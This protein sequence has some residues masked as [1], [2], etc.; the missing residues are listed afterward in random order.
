[1]GSIQVDGEVQ[2][3]T[4]QVSYSHP[5]THSGILRFSI[6]AIGLLVCFWGIWTTGRAGLSRLLATNVKRQSAPLTSGEE[7][8]LLSPSDPIPYAARAY[9]LLLSERFAEAATDYEAAIVR[10]PNDH[11]LWL[12]LGFA[13]ERSG[14]F[15]GA[16][17]AYKQAAQLAP[18]YA[19][20]R[21]YLGKRLLRSG[22][23]EEGFA[24]LR[25]AASSNSIL[26]PDLIALASTTFNGDVQAVARVVQP[27]TSAEHFA[28][29]RFFAERGTAS[30][31]LDLFR[32]AGGGSAEDRRKLLVALLDARRFAEAREVWASGREANSSVYAVTDGS[33]EN[34]IALDDSGF[35]W[36]LANN[37]QAF[38]ISL[39][40]NEPHSGSRS[41]RI[42]WSGDSAPSTS[43]ISQLVLVEPRTRYRLK[44]AARSR[45]LLTVGLPIVAVIDASD[46]QNVLVQSKALQGGTTGWQDYIT[47]FTTAENTGAVLISLRRES[48]AI[49]QCA[50]LGNLWLDDFLLERLY[51]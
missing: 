13:R 14:D 3:I 35:G 9:A 32:K 25:R 49:P 50:I 29:A 5:G 34:E 40:T 27:K 17:V 11:L 37:P 4:N 16:I 6:T 31:A 21:W 15:E 46:K 8:I 51:V 41:L 30:A 22:H 42:D 18:F 10:R 48:C 2:T 19:Q 12:R 38:H 20:P 43:V 24:E 47:E 39:D 1:M 33:F 44:F 7:A 28:L 36:Q 26:F 45:D 23:Q